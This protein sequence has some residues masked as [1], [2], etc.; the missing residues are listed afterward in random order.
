LLFN[1][2]QFL[3]FFPVVV[4]VYYLLPHK[5]RHIWLLISSYYFYMCWNAGYALLLLGSTL[6]TYASGLLLQRTNDRY[7]GLKQIRIKKCL[8]SIAIIL[9]LSVLIIFKY[10]DF[11]FDNLSKVLGILHMQMPTLE[12]S[13][14]LPVGIS[15]YIFQAL[16]YSIDV[17]RGT[18]KAER[19]FLYYALFV[20]FFPQLVAGPIERSANL[21]PQF[22]EKHNF[23]WDNLKSGLITMLWGY[24]MK[25]VI[26]DR[27]ALFVDIVYTDYPHHQGWFL[28]VASMLFAI[29]IYCDFAGYS[30]IAIGV[31]KSMGFTLMENFNSPYTATSVKD[32]WDRWHI[33][34]TGWFRD[35]LYIPLGG[36]RKG[37]VRKYI[38]QLFVFLVSGLW[39]GAMWSYV[40]WG[41]L[42]G[43]YL[44]VADIV[45]KPRNHIC[46]KLG[47]SESNH[48]INIIKTA[49]TFV[50]IDIT[51]VFFR[52]HGLTEAK[53]VFKN[54]FAVNNWS[55][56][57]DGEIFTAGLDKGEFIVLLVALLVLLL[58]DL[59]RKKNINLV[60]CL[61]TK[62]AFV[63]GMFCLVIIEII[64]VFGIWGTGYD[65]SAF[66]Y[67][68]F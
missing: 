38:N 33:S 10:L 57:N 58:V 51:W 40:L 61:L 1:S 7:E 30:T 49:V 44:V 37:K 16:G 22:K 43:C 46:N 24:F 4:L 26:A 42:N 50:L 14:L 45:S 52:A 8:L 3:A 29:Q 25:L 56:F 36:N 53:L 6:I 5:V 65:A 18:I 67:F 55:I 15:F 12:V 9:N 59:L 27:I 21:L 39:H 32:F 19:N 66:I 34:L 54:M 64:I 23:N 62:N 35:Y 13:L 17:Y 31:A 28:I 68:Q 47:I 11:L 48:L 20:S 63:Q 41:G 60:D 2:Y